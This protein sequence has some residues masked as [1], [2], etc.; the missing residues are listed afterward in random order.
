MRFPGFLPHRPSWYLALGVAAGVTV[1]AGYVMAHSSGMTGVAQSSNGC[2]CHSQA[3]NANGAVTV[4]ITGPASVQTGSTSAYTITV[5]GGPPGTEGGFDLKADAG[6]LVAG[7]GTWTTG[8]ELTHADNTQRSWSFTW[9]AP[10]AGTTAHFYAIAQ[11]CN[12]SGT[13]G[14]SWN[15][16]GG[17]VNT[18]FTIT[19]SGGAGVDGAGAATFWLAPAG[20]NP[21]VDATAI[22]FSLARPGTA[23]LEVFDPAG[24]HVALLASGPM[25]PGPHQAVWNGRDDAGRRTSAG[26]YLVRLQSGGQVRTTRV[27]RLTN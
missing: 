8:T 12:G 22:R 5:S 4:S 27:D 14:D 15:W 6:T 13:S 16:Y 7:T 23:R 11:S 20:P 9:T 2:S 17:A 19:V 18:P 10:A 3:P 1:W 25:S 26:V 24:R 21:F